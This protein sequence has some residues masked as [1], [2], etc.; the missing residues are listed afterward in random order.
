MR[1]EYIKKVKQQLAVSRQQKCELIR[2]LNEAF[3]SA[4]EHGET[5]KQVI[6]RLGSAKAFVNSIHEQFGINGIAREQR[7]KRMQIGI[8]ITIMSISFALGIIIRT[9]SVPENVIGQANSMTSIQIEGRAID[10]SLLFM[11]F[12]SA[13]LVIAV[14]LSIRYIRGKRRRNHE[15]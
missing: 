6:N 13:A 14:A 5:E 12:G 9:A 11:S 4:K 7:K 10:P 3:D 2:D 15:A 1:A 8:A